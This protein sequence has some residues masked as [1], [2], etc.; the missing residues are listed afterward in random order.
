MSKKGISV[1]DSDQ[2]ARHGDES[3]E[4]LTAE[5]GDLQGRQTSNKT[6]KH[7]AV[8]KLAASRPEFGPSP[9]AHPV[10]GAFGEGSPEEAE[11][12]TNPYL[13]EACNRR[14]NTEREFNEHQ[15]ECVTAKNAIRRQPRM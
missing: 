1:A 9:G 5:A 14:F 12:A 8:E 10:A 15:L 6:G 4:E 3:P 11:P 2:T 7:S 13:C